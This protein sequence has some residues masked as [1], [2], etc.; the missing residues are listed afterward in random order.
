MKPTDRHQ[1]LR[2]LFSHFKYT[3]R[4]IVYSQILRINRLCSLEKD[5]NYHELS[6]KDYFV[7]RGYPES[8]TEKTISSR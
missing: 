4:S 3:K 7:K 2:Y 5:F 6:M 8:V 1:Y